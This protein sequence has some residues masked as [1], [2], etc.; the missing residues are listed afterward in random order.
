[1]KARRPTPSDYMDQDRHP[2]NWP[3]VLTDRD[4]RIL[5][6]IHEYDGFLADYQVKDLE[7]TGMRQA[8]DRLGKLFHNG[9]LNRTNRRGRTRFGTMIY[10]LS[11]QGAEYVAGVQG[12]PREELRWM[13][14]LREDLVPHNLLVND[15]T[16]IL[17]QACAQSE[18]FNLYHWINESVFRADPDKVEYTTST[19][20]RT[21][22]NLIPDRYFL[23]EREGDRLFRSR[24]LL[25]LD[26]AT[27]PNKR[28]ADQ[29]VLPGI[30]YL[31]S[32][33]YQKRF[34]SQ[35]GRWLLVTTGDRRLSFLK[36]TT[37]RVAGRDATVWYFTTFDRVSVET[38]LTEPVW[39][40]GGS[41]EPVALFP[42][43]NS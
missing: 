27:H 40:K 18:E 29:K 30:A 26:V 23:V 7:F 28:F 20:K 22:R 10:W 12:V 39:Y 15:F 5:E 1:M 3:M 34:G 42:P 41:Q 35:S 6:H 21:G 16:L 37:E 43:K 13:K 9:Y 4:G 32:E 38:M 8:R 24:L 14:Q 33:A 31:R 11:A 25:E 2:D 19:G 17:Q 36:E